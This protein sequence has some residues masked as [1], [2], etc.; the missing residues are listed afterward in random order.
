MKQKNIIP[1]FVDVIIVNFKIGN[2]R[3]IP[4]LCF[5]SKA[6]QEKEF[7]VESINCLASPF[8]AVWFE[9]RILQLL[10]GRQVS[11]TTEYLFGD[12]SSFESDKTG[13]RHVDRSQ[14][15][16]RRPPVKV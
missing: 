2:F 15:G 5:F 7:I 6:F 10:V 4:C 13:K 16:Q 1:L 12:L 3:Y 14:A 11:A 8:E 9:D